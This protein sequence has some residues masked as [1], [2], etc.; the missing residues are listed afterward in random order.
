MT[1]RDI[2]V[3][4][5]MPNSDEWADDLKRQLREVGVP[6]NRVH[7]TEV[8]PERTFDSV[9]AKR[10]KEQKPRV[11]QIIADHDPSFILLLGNE[12]LMAVAG[13]SGIM[14]Y[15]GRVMEVHTSTGKVVPCIP[16]ISPSAIKR[17]PSQIKGYMADMHLFGNLVNNKATG[18]PDPKYA[19][20]D[21]VAKLK[22]L[23]RALANVTEI[24]FDVETTG[25]YYSP[26]GRLISFAAVCETVVNGKRGRFCFALPLYHPESV[27]RRKHR[28]VIRM[29]KEVL[30]AIPVVVAHNGSYDSKWMIAYGINLIVTFDTMHAQALLDENGAKGLKPVSQSRLGVAPWG[31]DT[32]DL[33]NM[34]ILEVLHYNM[35][36]CWYMY[37]IKRQISDDLSKEPRTQRLFE[38]ETMPA[39][40]ELLLSEMRGIWIDVERL[41]KR[42]PEIEDTLRQVELEIVEAAGLPD[43]ESDDWP[44]DAKG[45]PRAINFNASLF[46]RWM[47]FDWCG[48]RI[49][50]RGKDKDDGSPGEPS[51]A[52]HVLL[53]LVDDH[54]VVQ[55]MLDRVEWQKYLSSFII[56][57]MELY[58]E[59]HR[60]H[61]NFKLSGTVTGR[62]S[63]GKT[64]ADKVSGQRGKIRGVNLQQV[65]RNA[66]IR[67]LFGAPPGWTFVEADYSQVELRIAAFMAREKNMMALYRDGA[68]IHTTTA[69]RVAGIPEGQVSKDVRKK[70]GKPVNFGFL[71]GMG[72]NKF[73]QTAFSNY[74]AIFSMDEA[75]AARKAYFALYPDLVEWHNRQRRLVRK[76]GRVQSP[77]GRVRHLPD[78]FSPDQGVAAEAERQAINS[79]VQGFA[80]DLAVIAMVEINK[81]FRRRGI[82]GYCL[83]L[84][85]DAINY[86]IR[87]D[88]VAMALP[89]IKDRMEDM[90]FIEQQFGVNVDVPIIS[91]VSVG[92]HWGDKKELT[93]AQVYDY[94]PAFKGE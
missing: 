48:L 40:R 16:T 30:E 82:A 2:L 64:D 19:I 52:E 58:D 25:E 23:K 22:S 12:A 27:W 53:A 35:L 70:L 78:I 67:G 44:T 83:G 37:W 79:P 47:L 29:F 76:Y 31:V 15:R 26:E 55:K 73:I 3:I 89:I 94:D 5:K 9:S 45:H 92:Q 81:E 42:G 21:T 61:T 63:S 51:M 38:L 88:H 84:V 11:A 87:N 28:A 57:Y 74:G 41:N 54:P 34:P 91:D 24:N 46:A 50:E 17:N 86:E 32:S 59:D 85:H 75:R 14:K 90:A 39:E 68:D 77:L 36:D 49:D 60:I 6:L 43:P 20:I 71:Y 66:I 4:S 1:R 65:P 69:A 18:I 72:P 80:S 7:F 62:L 33:I 56:P 10:V 93:P 8:I 13:N